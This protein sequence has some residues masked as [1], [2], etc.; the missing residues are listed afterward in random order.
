MK[1]HTRQI[2]ANGWKI[3]NEGTLSKRVY[4][5]A[6]T[7]KNAREISGEIGRPFDTVNSI[8]HGFMPRK[9][10][11]VPPVER[12]PEPQ[13]EPNPMLPVM[14]VPEDRSG[15]LADCLASWRRKNARMARLKVGDFVWFYGSV[16]VVGRI[17]EIDSSTDIATIDWD[18]K[19]A[20]K[21][22]TPRH[23]RC[24]LLYL[25]RASEYCVAHSKF[26][27]VHA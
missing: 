2:D 16:M 27:A 3:P 6:V 26:A 15:T 8:M 25:A 13:T 18:M 23:P 11:P 17:T 7:G 22:T 21:Y 5:L 14:S 4:D 24:Y 9:P 20:H 19:D 10:Q 1:W 12:S